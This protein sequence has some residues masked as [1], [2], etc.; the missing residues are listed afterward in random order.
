MSANQWNTIFE[1]S[2]DG[3]WVATIAEVPGAITQG[4]TQE[5]AQSTVL[6]AL[7]ELLAYRMATPEGP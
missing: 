7:N 5:E 6:D 4:R 3:W 1:W 2:E